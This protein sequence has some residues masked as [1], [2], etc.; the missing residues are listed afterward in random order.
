ML[1]ETQIQRFIS[2][3]IYYQTKRKC[4]MYLHQDPY[5]TQNHL[6]SYI[7]FFKPSLQKKA[8]LSLFLE[9][10]LRLETL[11]EDLRPLLHAEYFKHIYDLCM[12]ELYASFHTTGLECD[13][14][15][16]Q[17]HFQV[18]RRDSCLCLMLKATTRVL[19]PV[20]F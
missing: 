15:F 1:F 6:H 14:I 5:A 17:A 4:L 8:A 18:I 7:Y 16:F 10:L 11:A 12:Y 2:T 19:F 9:C 3:R 13:H 20:S